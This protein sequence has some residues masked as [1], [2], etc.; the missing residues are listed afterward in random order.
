MSG[1]KI[2]STGKNNILLEKYVMTGKI[3]SY[4]KKEFTNAKNAF[5]PETT[6]SETLK[7][8]FSTGIFF[9]FLRAV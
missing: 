2:F 4:W 8:I 6:Q 5:L 7:K 3:I 9:Y 1:K